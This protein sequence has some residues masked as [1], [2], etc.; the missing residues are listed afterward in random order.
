MTTT[1]EQPYVILTYAEVEIAD[2]ETL[3]S[4]I[5]ARDVLSREEATAMYVLDRR[6]GQRFHTE[7][8]A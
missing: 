7:R 1:P 3:E 6:T 8:V 5:F 2:A 4:A